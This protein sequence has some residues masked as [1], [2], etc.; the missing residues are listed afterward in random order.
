MEIPR[1]DKLLEKTTG[2]LSKVDMKSIT[3]H[4]KESDNAGLISTSILSTY[5]QSSK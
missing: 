1:T 5:F 2:Y 3:K 4:I